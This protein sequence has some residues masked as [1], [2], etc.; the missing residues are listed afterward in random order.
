M[1]FS[2]MLSFDPTQCISYTKVRN[3]EKISK[4]TEKIDFFCQKVSVIIKARKDE[5]FKD[6]IF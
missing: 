3:F 5:I 1:K 6:V 4:K 2:R